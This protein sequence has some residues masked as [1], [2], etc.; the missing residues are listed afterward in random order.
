MVVTDLHGDWDT[1]RRYRDRFVE[2]HAKRQADC[3]IFTGD[4]IHRDVPTDPDHSLEIV[5]DI[6]KSQE[7]FGEAI[8][9]L[10][11][12]HELPHIYG[13]GLGKGEVDYTAGFEAALSQSPYRSTVI[14]LFDSLPFYVRTAAGVS[15]TH[16]GAS[17]SMMDEQNGQSTVQVIM[18][19][20]DS[21]MLFGLQ[22]PA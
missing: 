20:P 3:L 21:Q 16:A 2:L 17:E 9:C 11:G 1:Y 18:F 8:I 14:S 10:C 19:S 15:V 22:P 5:L 6:V 7:T 12:N 4:L 13:F